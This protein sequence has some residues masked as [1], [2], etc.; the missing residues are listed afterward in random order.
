MGVTW[1]AGAA[2][3]G[4]TAAL[5]LPWYVAACCCIRDFAY[6]F[7]WEHNVLRFLTPFAHEQGVWFYGPVVLLGL[8]P[9]TL[10][11]IP[12]I[13]FLCSGDAAVA[14]RRT[15][16][17]GFLLLAGGWCVLFFT[18][19]SC[20]LPTYVMPAFPP[21][22]LALGH[23]LAHSRLGA[24]RWPAAAAAASFLLLAGLH[25]VA[26]PWYAAYRSPMSRPDEVRR[27]CA[28]PATPLACYP[29]NCDAVAFYLGRDDLHSYHNKIEDLRKLVR[30]NPRTVILCTHRHSLH[31]LGQLLPPEAHIVEVVHL[32]LGRLPVP[33]AG[34]VSGALG[35]TA[36]GL[37]DLAVVECP[38][39]SGP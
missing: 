20:K 14:R 23:Y 28:D 27:L 34:D 7:F 36:M 18:L 24:T 22:A 30:A 15:P 13:R 33:L 37:S 38:T 25:H 12:F 26:A 1:R 19:S 2:Y 10:L 6:A 9:G 3:L 21:L 31:D 17:L 11:A 5:P 16:E 4:V 29:N 8:L 32:G 39:A 35:E